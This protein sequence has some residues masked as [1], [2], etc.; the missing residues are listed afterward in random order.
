[1][2]VQKPTSVENSNPNPVILQSTQTL[3][4]DLRYHM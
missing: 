1:M 4:M 3:K 2:T